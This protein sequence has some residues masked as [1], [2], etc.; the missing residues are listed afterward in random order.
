MLSASKPWSVAPRLFLVHK[1]GTQKPNAAEKRVV[2][3]VA[4]DHNLKSCHSDQYI[5][6][7]IKVFSYEGATLRGSTGTD[8][9]TETTSRTVATARS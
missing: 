7:Q 4:N 3:S 9:G 8:I 2:I 5:S 1:E 6:K